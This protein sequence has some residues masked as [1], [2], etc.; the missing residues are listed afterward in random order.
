MRDKLQDSQ[1]KRDQERWARKNETIGRFQ[2][3][4]LGIARAK[5]AREDQEANT[6]SI[7]FKAAITE[8]VKELD[9]A[10]IILNS[11]RD[12]N[13]ARLALLNEAEKREH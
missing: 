3:E 5:S 2:N 1:T 10:L 6:A 9:L 12:V 4:K 13:I 11:L 7:D 8:D